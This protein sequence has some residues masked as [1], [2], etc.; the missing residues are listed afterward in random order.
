MAPLL[1]LIVGGVLLAAFGFLIGY[2]VGA[3]QCVLSR[4]RKATAD[5]ERDMRVFEAGRA[6]GAYQ[7]SKPGTSSIDPVAELVKGAVDANRRRLA[8]DVLGYAA[9]VHGFGASPI[10]DPPKPD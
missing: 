9:R 7:A 6:V 10:A 4:L 2:V 3:Y 5:L 8:A 1:P